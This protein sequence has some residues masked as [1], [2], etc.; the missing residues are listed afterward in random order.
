MPH[1]PISRRGFIEATG[2]LAAT[3]TT[4][5]S[6]ASPLQSTDAQLKGLPLPPGVRLPA[7][8]PRRKRDDSVGFAIVG[9][10]GY[11]L[12]QMM[13]RFDQADRAH[14]AALIGDGTSSAA[15]A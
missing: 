4:T 6:A 9:L 11:A 1:T 5:A 7:T 8:P 14:I 15:A 13:P 12:N 2:A 3:L 10:G